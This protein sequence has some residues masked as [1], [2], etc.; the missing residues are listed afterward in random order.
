ME[1]ETHKSGARSGHAASQK[2]PPGQMQF[3]IVKKK[4][5]VVLHLLQVTHF[6]FWMK[7]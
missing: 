5:D 1:D 6:I 4:T 2:S 3:F 7:Q